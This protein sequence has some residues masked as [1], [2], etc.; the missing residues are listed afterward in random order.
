[1]AQEWKGRVSWRTATSFDAT[2][3]IISALKQA[4][5]RVGIEQVLRHPQFVIQGATGMIKFDST[6]GDR[7]GKPVVVQVKKIAPDQYDFVLQR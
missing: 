6:T 1:M 7:I 2:N 3:V 5:T 4:D